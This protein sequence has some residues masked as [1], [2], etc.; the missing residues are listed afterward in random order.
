L[1]SKRDIPVE[2]ID[3]RHGNDLIRN[4]IANGEPFL[5]GRVGTT[6]LRCY[7]HVNG[8]VFDRSIRRRLEE[9]SGI[10]PRSWHSLLTFANL[11][12]NCLLDTDFLVTFR[13]DYE[14]KLKE[15]LKA[16]AHILPPKSLEPY[17]YPGEGWWHELSDKRV[18]FVNSAASEIISRVNEETLSKV[19]PN[20]T[21]LESIIPKK[22]FAVD[23]PYGWDKETRQQYKTYLRLFEN[24][25]RQI[26]KIDFDIAL[27]G[28]GG[29]GF[30]LA[31]WI[32]KSGKPAIHLG[33][34]IQLWAGFAGKRHRTSIPWKHYINEHWAPFP[35]SK[36]PKD[37]RLWKDKY[38]NG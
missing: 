15:K 27:I 23:T 8:I 30:P 36:A 1:D 22:M 2:R 21:G 12:E 19:W 4:C 9:N 28:C 14:Y 18:L 10:F 3:G 32:R 38:G 6:E 35:E 34:V 16:S 7:L 26:E 37:R 25:K 13:L 24:L 5:A 17:F 29:Y 20:E 33:G 11:I 31:H